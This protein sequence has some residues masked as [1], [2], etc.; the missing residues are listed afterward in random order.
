MELWVGAVVLGF[1]YAFMSMGVFITFRV[2]NFPDITVDGSFTTGAATC[3]ALIVAGLHPALALLGALAVGMAAGAATG[4]IHTR[5][6]VNGLLSGILVMTGLY[7]VNLHIMGRSNIPLLQ[8]ATLMSGLEGLNPGLPSEVWLILHLSLIMAGF[9]LL[10]T[11]FFKSDLGMAMRATGDNAVMAAANGVGVNRLTV[12]GLAVANGLVGVSGGLVAQYQG[13]ADVTMGVGTIVV[14]LASVII[15]ESLLRVK[16]LYGQVLGAIVGSVVFRLMIAVALYLGLNPIDLKILTAAFVLLTLVLSRLTEGGRLRLPSLP[17]LSRLGKRRALGLAAL[18]AALGLGWWSGL[19]ERAPSPALGQGKPLVAVLQLTDNGLLNI[20]RESMLA[21][22]G[23]LGYVDGQNCRLRVDNAHG[24]MATVSLILDKFLQDDAAV[25]VTI[26]TGATQA[27]L[28]KIKDRP[29]IFA[30]VANPFVIHAGQSETDHLPNVTGVYGWAPMDKTMAMV[31]RIFAG[32]LRIGAVWDPSQANAVFNVKVLRSAVAATP[33]VSFIGATVSGSDDVYQAVSSL[34][35]KGIDVFVLPTDN[36]VYSAFDAVVSAA[37]DTPIVISDV[38]R[39]GDGALM[40]LGYDY[41]S[42]GQQAA[43]LV[44]RV[45]EGENPKN[46]PF[47]RYTRLAIGFDLDVARR[48][49]IDIPP[50]LLAQAT[51]VL[52][53]SKDQTAAS[54]APAAKPKRL[55]IFWFADIP[56]L[57]ESVRGVQDELAESGV[58][59]ERNIEVSLQSGQGDFPLAQSVAQN[60]ARQDFDYVITVS[61]QALQ[62][63][64][65]FNK[66]IP[67]VFGTVTDPYLAGVAKSPKEHQP[68]L[69]GLATFQPIEALFKTAR[70]AFPNARRIGLAWNPGEASSEACTLLARRV[71][72]KYGFELVETNVFS[73]ADVQEAVNGLLQQGIDLF[74]TSG[75]NVMMATLETVAHMLRDKRVP[76]IT[77]VCSDVERGA[78]L[79]VGAAY[80]YVGRATARLAMRVFAGENPK[81]IPIEDYVHESIFINEPLAKEFGLTWPEEVVR[82]ADNVKKVER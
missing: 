43:R 62:L 41:A 47:E 11:A 26:S 38:E 56:V 33:E 25:V 27:A 14:G 20:T 7:S 68:N 29:L 39:L 9:W 2:Y 82:A 13:F 36:I 71:A 44:Q 37:K 76:L 75:D 10:T 23:R 64:A 60:I 52:D 45:L 79:S 49:K 21:E 70:Q 59:R 55:A 3:A 42:S 46:I 40:A 50:E 8:H 53:K 78:M 22:L 67:H 28:K 77:N 80:Y 4:L 32:R 15:G 1:L 54:A 19:A 5:L 6:G 81:D 31:R 24:D 51:V 63:M 66:T 72:P 58:L 61:T 12:F 34:E 17:A 35:E 57:L 74:F 16:S 48:L 69:T 30:T 65:N 73:T 18:V